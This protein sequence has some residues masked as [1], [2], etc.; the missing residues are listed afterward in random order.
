LTCR[1]GKPLAGG[2]P[3]AAPGWSPARLLALGLFL[4]ALGTFN[5][6][7]IRGKDSPLSG[8]APTLMGLTLLG[9]AYKGYNP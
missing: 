1:C 5:L 2:A 6:V 9:R 3:R 8:V 7:F 4:L